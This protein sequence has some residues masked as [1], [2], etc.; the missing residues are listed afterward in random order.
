MNPTRPWILLYQWAAGLCDTATGALL[1]AAPAWTFALMKLTV[2]PRPVA[3][4]RFVGAFVFCVG[5]T[6]LWAAAGWPL[7]EWR[8]QWR[9]TALIRTAA[10]LLLLWQIASGAMERGWMAVL[11]T[12]GILAAFQWIG[13]ARNWLDAAAQG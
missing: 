3:F 11:L 8:T 4:V 6:Y 12:D 7:S 1:I 9:I 5:F 2:L 13:L 10:A